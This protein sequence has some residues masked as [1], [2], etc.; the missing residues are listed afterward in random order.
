MS[1]LKIRECLSI[2]PN[3]APLERFRIARTLPPTLF[4]DEIE[5]A[6][7]NYHLCV[8]F[9]AITAVGPFDLLGTSFSCRLQVTPYL[10]ENSEFG[11]NS[12]PR[13]PPRCSSNLNLCASHEN[14]LP[15]IT[16]WWGLL[17]CLVLR[18]SPYLLWLSLRSL[19]GPKV[20]GLES[21]VD[22]TVEFPEWS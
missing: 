4:L 6:V 1:N 16:F 8:A 22:C 2:S 14:I 17:L 20:P 21:D 7:R 3:S 18:V 12:I 5:S 9:K 11:P 13:V 19:L 15:F 10:H